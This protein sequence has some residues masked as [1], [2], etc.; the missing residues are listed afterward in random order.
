MV[1]TESPSAATAAAGVAPRSLAI[2]EA[3]GRHLATGE[4]TR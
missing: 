1:A 2:Y 4:A 3:V